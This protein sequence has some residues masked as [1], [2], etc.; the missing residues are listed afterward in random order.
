MQQIFRYY[1][2]KFYFFTNANGI[3]KQNIEITFDLTSRN[4][5]KT[6]WVLNIFISSKISFMA[7]KMTSTQMKQY[8]YIKI[9]ML[10]RENI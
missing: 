2:Y 9:W 3:T 8:I 1:N 6:E 10:D 4:H 5:N 7:T